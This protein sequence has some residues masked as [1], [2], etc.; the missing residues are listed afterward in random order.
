M[1]ALRVKLNIAKFY[2]FSKYV[3]LFTIYFYS[4]EDFQG[5]CG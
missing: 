4:P 1:K 3:L 2:T 5:F